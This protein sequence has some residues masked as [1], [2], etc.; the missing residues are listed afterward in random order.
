MAG[1]AASVN[2]GTDLSLPSGEE[3]AAGFAVASDL[4][5][6]IA[7]WLGWLGDERR[8]ADL[9]VEAYRRDLADF[10]GFIT[11]HLGA[12]PDLAQIAGLGRA[13]FR[14]WMASRSSRGLQASSTARALSAIK[15]FYRLAI[16]RGLIDQTSLTALRTPK[17]P[18][19][20]PK[21]LTAPEAMEA[22]SA[23]GDQQH[24][25]WIGKRDI[26]ILTLLY[27]CG[28]RISE[29]LSLTRGDVPAQDGRAPHGLGLL[30]ILGKGRKERVV[31]ILPVV[32]AAIRDYL[33]A[34]PYGGDAGDPLF[35][36][37]RGGVLNP[38]LI[39]R[40]MQQLR[41]ALGLPETATP[42]ALR[43]SFATHLLAGGGDLRA[44]QELLGHA[45][46]STTQR[47]TEV[48]AAQLMAV[49]NA[50]HPRAKN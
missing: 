36:G 33:A 16:K 30:R 15:S 38:R 11:G 9:T 50:A 12:Q 28:L 22:V 37:A 35:V 29:A 13:D 49:Y 21:P 42:H 26:A 3:A 48:D 31:P 14:A 43:H 45:S 46:L 34:C 6:A 27:G 25:S 41:A 20:L 19:S 10:L 23:I 44:I 5:E 39:Q 47:Y 8:A 1:S 4:K 7:I 32:V 18:R 40:A 17:L 2:K 24:E